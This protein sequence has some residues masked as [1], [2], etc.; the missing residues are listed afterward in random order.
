[1]LGSLTHNDTVV[2]G[3]ETFD[4]HPVE[5]SEEYTF[6]PSYHIDSEGNIELESIDIIW[7]KETEK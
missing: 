3:G 2:I 6:G 7:K 5:L 4:C 1:M